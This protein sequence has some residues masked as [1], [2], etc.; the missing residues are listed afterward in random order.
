MTFPLLQVLRF[1]EDLRRSVEGQ[2]ND[3][4]PVTGPTTAAVTDP[5]SAAIIGPTAAAA[6]D[7][8]SAAITGPTA[9]AATDPGNAS[10]TDPKNAD[11]KDPTT[12]A[13]DQTNAERLVDFA[14]L[15]IKNWLVRYKAKEE[16][17]DAIAAQLEMM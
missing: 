2:A 14:V 11:S 12:A 4:S 17:E 6:T 9:A 5:G 1:T 16:H 10:A 7:P 13:M 3:H 15:L 8:G